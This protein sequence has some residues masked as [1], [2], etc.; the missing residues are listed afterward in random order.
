MVLEISLIGTDG[1]EPA[2]AGDERHVRLLQGHHRRTEER[3]VVRRQSRRQLRKRV[4]TLL[5]ANRR[6][7][8]SK[9]GPGRDVLL[10][11][12]SLQL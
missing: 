12:P 2:A 9:P 3:V 10:K 5:S 4:E 11:R 8:C 7:L 1:A 6:S